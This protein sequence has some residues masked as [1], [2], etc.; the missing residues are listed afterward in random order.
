MDIRLII[1]ADGP[2]SFSER[3]PGGIFQHSL[4]YVPGSALRGALAARLLDGPYA[5]HR[6]HQFHEDCD[7]CRVFLGPEAAI[8]TNA[9]PARDPRDEVQ[10]LPASAVSCKRA[11]GFR[12]AGHGVFDTLVDRLCWEALE[13]A[14]LAYNPIC[15]VCQNRVEAFGGFYVCHRHG[16]QPVHHHKR[17]VDQRLLTRVAINRRR[18]VAEEGLLFSPYVISE[19]VEQDK[20]SSDDKRRYQPTIFV[21]YVWGLPK[22]FDSDQLEQ[23]KAV[24]GRSSRGLGHVNIRADKLDAT[25]DGS[26]ALQERVTALDKMLTEAWQYYQRLGGNGQ[27]KKGLYF[28]LTLRSDAVLRTLDGLP[29]MI[30][31][32]DMLAKATG[33]QAELVRSYA[34][35]AYGG[36][37]QSAWG[38]PKPSQV[39]ARAGTVY[40]FRADRLTQADYQALAELEVRG[41]GELTP[42]GYGQV[43]VSDAFHLKRRDM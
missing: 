32:A 34:S 5:V 10:V 43:R 3:K 1:R 28:T 12:S 36:G 42:E 26:A 41:I 21:G 23:V 30:F 7:F 14:G 18:M 17:N 37:W 22:D 31:G 38:L 19:M 11:S 9:Y 16:D 4:P 13:P 6:T 40:V 20:H 35:Y 29:T 27:V 24:G 8:F 33:G 39:L 25:G 2:L 15:P